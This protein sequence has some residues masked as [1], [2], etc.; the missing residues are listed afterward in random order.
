MP[1]PAAIPA[2]EEAARADFYA[3]LAALFHHAPDAKLLRT[4][5]LAPAMQGHEALSQAWSGLV[6]AS[7]VMDGEALAQEYEALFVGVGKAKVSAYAGWYEAQAAA[8]PMRV[9]V[10]EELAALGLVRPAGVNEPQDHFAALFEAMRLLVAGGAG[11]APAG[12]ERQRRFF[13]A[14]VRPGAGRFLAAVREAPEANYYRKV[15]AVGEAFLAIEVESF[16]LG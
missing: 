5:A 7:A 2:P 16:D 1:D 14:F 8:V 6:A 12:L 11:R 10:A 13:E 3:L 15:A 4:I 9:R